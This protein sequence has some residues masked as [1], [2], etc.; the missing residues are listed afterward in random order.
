MYKQVFFF[1]YNICS[2]HNSNKILKP[3]SF[4][5]NGIKITLKRGD[6]IDNVVQKINDKKYHTGGITAKKVKLGGGG[7]KIVL[8]STGRAINILDHDNVLQDLR[9][10]NCI[11][12]YK[13]K[14]V[15][16]P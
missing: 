13:V 12:E 10:K 14:S 3:C 6:T 16:Q 8:Q 5:L 9:K 7:C 2:D 11:I 1:I 4:K 15:P